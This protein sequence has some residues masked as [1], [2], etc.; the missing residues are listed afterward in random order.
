MVCGSRYPNRRDLALYDDSLSNVRV[1]SVDAALQHADLVFL[2][3]PAPATVK[4]LTPY[5]D[6]TAGKILVDV[7]NPEKKDLQKATA[8]NAEFVAQSFPAASVV[9]AFNTMSAYAI[10]NDYGSGVRNV[11]VAGDDE[12]ACSKVR[13]IT[14]AIGFS[15]VQFGRLSKSA[16]L[17]AMQR[18]LFGSWTAPLVLSG[19]I[20]VAWF[21]YDLWRIHIIGDGHWARLPLQTMNKVG[22]RPLLLFTLQPILKFSHA[23]PPFVQTYD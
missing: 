9:K 6:S 8:S 23:I 11:Y 4:T 17:E 18:E 16:E 21:V 2:A 10:E 3:L 5:A 19:V 7:S 13:G 20:F 15:P 14:S 1:T 22:T 12:T